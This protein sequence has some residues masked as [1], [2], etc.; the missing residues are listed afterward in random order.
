MIHCLGGHGRTGT[1]VCPL[2]AILIFFKDIIK[3]VNKNEKLIWKEWDEKINNIA[4]ELFIRAQA[5]IMLS[6][7]CHRETNKADLKTMKEIKIPETHAQ[8]NVALD[9]IKLYIKDYL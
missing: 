1:V 9:I 8:D 3:N 5:Y 7:R 6:L 2:I 4:L